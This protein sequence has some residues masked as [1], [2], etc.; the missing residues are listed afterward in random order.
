MVSIS[1][2]APVWASAEPARGNQLW[3]PRADE[4][5]DFAE[6]VTRR[7]AASVDHYG[8]SNEPNQGVWLQP[9]SD[10]SGLVAP[11][12]YRDMVLAAY[13][14]IKAIDPTATALVG[15]L[16]ASGRVRPR[17]HPADP[18]AAVPARDGLPRLPLAPGPARALQEL[19][20]D[21]DRCAGP[22]P[23]QP[24]SAADQPL[25]QQVRRGHRRR[26]AADPDLGP[27]GAPACA[28][29]GPRAAA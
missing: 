7:Y 16:A 9:Q 8:I 20:A 10:R 26:P 17:R 1:T 2:P 15:E 18:A 21:P 25:D 4:F 3:K 6:A 5:A 24:A 27:A 29:A 22:P 12:L 11:H 14:R 19:Q 28:Q 23:V 13:P